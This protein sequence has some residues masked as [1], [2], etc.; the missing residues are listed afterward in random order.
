MKEEMREVINQHLRDIENENNVRIL[1]AVE[2]GS[3][4]WGFA[5]PDSDWDVRFIYVHRPEWY[6]QI[7]EGRDVIEHM[8]DDEVDASGWDLKKALYLFRRANTS[9]LEWLHSPIVYHQDNDFIETMHKLEPSYFDACKV[10]L[11][12][13]GMYISHNERYLQ[14]QQYPLKRFLYYLRG[15]LACKWIESRGSMPPILFTELLTSTVTDKTIVSDILGILRLK[16]ESK[17]HNNTQV[18]L[19]LVEFAENMAKYYAD[20]DAEKLSK[21]EKGFETKCDELDKL[22]YNTVMQNK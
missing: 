15:I 3:R 17:E 8:Y 14:G 4:A 13:K 5:S 20:F 18:D 1:L 9:L 19:R 16:S 11:N 10:L 21:Q 12:Y 2:S 6:L 7:E 22:L